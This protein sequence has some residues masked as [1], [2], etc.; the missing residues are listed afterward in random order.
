MKIDSFK[1]LRDE[2]KK[3]KYLPW[4]EKKLSNIHYYEL[5]E[6]LQFKKAERV[7]SCAEILEFKQDKETGHKTLYK[8]WFCKSRLC[9][10]CNWRRSMKNG[11]QAVKV[12]E[13]VIKRRPTVRWL[14]LTISTKNVY[15]GAE[16]D[17]SIRHMHASFNRL[18]KYKKVQKNL[19]GFMR[20]TEVTVNDV[21]NSYNQ[22]IH[23]LLAVKS[24]YFENESNYIN[25]SEWRKLWQR[26]LKIDYLPYAHI[27]IVKPKGKYKTKTDGVKGA[28]LEVAKYPVKD[29]DYLTDDLGTDLIRVADLEKGLNR[30]RLI[31]YGGLLNDI[32]KE[33]ELSDVEDGD[34]IH[35]DEDAIKEVED[36][37]AYTIIA[38]WH[39]QRQ[40]Y[41]IT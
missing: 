40:N 15:D 34:L 8:A 24:T 31:G 26:A 19:I 20:A 9:P 30:K 16:L 7:G 23:V 2:T 27:S 35:V 28:L 41:I 32:R 3:G 12:V 25:Q 1:V 4:K 33:L 6:I 17:E 11:L 14:F 10:I 29:V 13:E 18:M 36:D 21:D 22:H 38:R 5:I 39:W 37:K